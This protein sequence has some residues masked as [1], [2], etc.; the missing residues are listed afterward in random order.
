MP[1]DGI[2]SPTASLGKQESLDE[3][4]LIK[5][6]FAHSDKEKYGWPSSEIGDDCAILSIGATA[7]AVTADM[8][9][10]GTHFLDDADPYTVGRKALAVNLS[11]LAAAGAVPKA[12]FLS[13]AL[14]EA[15]PIWLKEFSKGLFEEAERYRC[16]LRG[17]DTTKAAPVDG[18][19]GKTCISICAMGEVDPEMFL[20][21]AGA[22]PGDDIWVSGTPGDAYAALGSIWNQFEVSSEDFSYFKSRMDLPTPRVELGQKIKS[23]ANACC[24][25]S[26]GLVGDLK[27]I[28][29]RS[30]VSA[31]LYWK[32]F[33][34]SE[35]IARLP[36]DVQRRC[37]L[38]GGDD[39]ELI[40]TAPKSNRSKIEEL[41]QECSAKVTRIGKIVPEAESYRV[42]DA[43][44][45]PI[46]VAES[47]NHF[48]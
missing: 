16:P 23:L 7:V 38:S 45:N 4:S 25:I 15:N 40:F 28:L 37:I 42:L 17:G 27:H 46:R 1:D 5:R 2:D 31:V 8:M 18:K 3:F 32:D 33:P 21:R 36:E 19:P 20:T 11:D 47:F 26:D 29:E 44:G 10:L 14:P 41:N 9:A 34:K 43:D 30:H 48:A 22:E 35:Q 24:D 39:Y 6:F 13:I 12:F